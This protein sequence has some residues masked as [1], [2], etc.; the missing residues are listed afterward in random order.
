MNFQDAVPE[1]TS[2]LAANIQSSE[3]QA[4]DFFQ[5]A[6]SAKWTRLCEIYNEGPRF[7]HLLWRIGSP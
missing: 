7:K 3:S 6:L 5:P 4:L 2:V 1:I